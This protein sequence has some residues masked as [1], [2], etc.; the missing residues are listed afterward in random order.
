MQ[1]LIPFE[2]ANVVAMYKDIFAAVIWLDE[3]KA[4]LGVKPLYF[5]LC[6]NST[7]KFF[8][9]EKRS[10]DRRTPQPLGSAQFRDSALKKVMN[11]EQR[12]KTKVVRYSFNEPENSGIK[13][14]MIQYEPISS[15]HEK[16]RQGQEPN[17][18]K[19]Q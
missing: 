15:I 19:C 7:L 2:A 12:V 17:N 4:F 3:A 10:V 5:S 8:T 11:Y 14:A 6:H 16:R 1:P 13:S 18:E 9:A